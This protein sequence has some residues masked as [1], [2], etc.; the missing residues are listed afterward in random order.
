MYVLQTKPML[1]LCLSGYNDRP[2]GAM[3]TFIN[4]CPQGEHRVVERLG[5]HTFI[6]TYVDTFIFSCVYMVIYLCSST[7]SVSSSTL[8]WLVYCDTFA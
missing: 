5:M 4:V 2:K 8:R 6:Y 1:L 3:N 7:R